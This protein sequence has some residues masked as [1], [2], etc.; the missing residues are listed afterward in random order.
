[1]LGYCPEYDFYRGFEELKKWLDN[2]KSADIRPLAEN[3][4]VN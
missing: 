2:S 4:T 1:M 3:S